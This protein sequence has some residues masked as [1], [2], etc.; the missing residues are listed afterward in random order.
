MATG[1]IIRQHLQPRPECEVLFSPLILPETR[2]KRTNQMNTS[3]R[4]RTLQQESGSEGRR[5]RADDM[6][7]RTVSE[8]T[9]TLSGGVS[10]SPTTVYQ[11]VQR[12]SGSV[13]TGPKAVIP[14]GL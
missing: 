14:S 13:Y 11:C 8:G 1:T 9:G 12:L 4:Q 2:Y 3:E 7:V 6:Y 10:S 5:H